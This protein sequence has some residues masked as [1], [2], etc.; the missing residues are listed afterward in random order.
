MEYI[1][2]VGEPKECIFCAPSGPRSDAERLILARSAESLVLLNR[3]PYAPGH[4]LV[5]PH[6]HAARLS[7]LEDSARADLMRW[8]AVSERILWEHYACHGLNVGANLGGDAGA[9]FADHLH[10]HLVPRWRGDHNFITVVGET[11]V[12]PTH[13]E[14]IYA[15]LLPHFRA[16]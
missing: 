16:L 3:Y 1:A 13:L 4:L 14:T 5:A 12:I 10:F 9:G 11:R 15:E 2:R 8:L 6:V 7:D